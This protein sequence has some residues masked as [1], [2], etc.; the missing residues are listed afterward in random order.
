M[1]L[2]RKHQRYSPAYA[3]RQ[4]AAA[5]AAY[6]SWDKLQPKDWRERADR[7]QALQT[8]GA[9]VDRWRRVLRP[10]EV[11]KYRLPF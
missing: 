11:E 6:A 3:R 9:A 10:P 5:E 8:W 7:H 1:T 2:H 4:L